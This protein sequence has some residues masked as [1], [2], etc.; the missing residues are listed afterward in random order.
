MNCDIFSAFIK[1][2]KFQTFKIA[3]NLQSWKSCNLE[4]VQNIIAIL[5][6]CNL[7]INERPSAILQSCN[8][9]IFQDCKQSCNLAILKYK[10]DFAILQSCNLEIQSKIAR[11]VEGAILQSCNLVL[12]VIGVYNLVHLV[13]RSSLC[14]Y[15]ERQNAWIFTKSAREDPCGFRKTDLVCGVR[16][17]CAATE[18]SIVSVLTGFDGKSR[19]FWCAVCGVRCAVCGVRCAVCGA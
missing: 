14:T 15:G 9:E 12:Q 13:R 7:E 1:E 19:I 11:S 2:L 3:S 4:I 16:S 6:S 18:V 5:Q 8:L 10:R 17:W